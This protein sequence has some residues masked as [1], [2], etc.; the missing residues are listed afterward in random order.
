[1]A[2]TMDISKMKIAELKKELKERGLSMSGNKSDLQE[3]LRISIEE[4]G[5][6]NDADLLADVSAEVDD[7][8]VAALEDEILDETETNTMI[9]EDALTTD[10]VLE[11]LEASLVDA[12]VGIDPPLKVQKMIT[13]SP[14]HA[15]VLMVKESVV[16]TENSVNKPTSDSEKL[17]ERVKKYGAQSE[18]SKKQMRAA[19]FNVG[20]T[21]EETNS[22]GA[23][24]ITTLST[25]KTGEADVLVRRAERFG[26]IS[27]KVAKLDEE[28]RKN[29]RQE[30]FGKDLQVSA[31]AD[32]LGDKKITKIDD[33]GKLEKRKERFG[34]TTGSGDAASLDVAMDRKRKRAERFGLI[35][36]PGSENVPNSSGGLV[37]APISSEIDEKKR[38]RAER[39]GGI[40]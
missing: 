4:A 1:M 28:T 40:A 39:F 37:N 19:R 7:D 17:L 5:E 2:T 38:K 6:V 30:R 29:K 32:V 21:S 22:V 12:G 11:N 20:Q 35:N 14:Q 15:S 23:K 9:N 31:T 8:D 25:G 3:R 18:D 34:I 27:P 16:I 26:L 36:S 13:K 10:D 24:S 33:Q